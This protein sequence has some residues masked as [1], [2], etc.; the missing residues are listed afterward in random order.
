MSLMI[1]MSILNPQAFVVKNPRYISVLQEG[2][3][4]LVNKNEWISYSLMT[5]SGLCN[6]RGGFV[7]RIDSVNT[8]RSWG[9]WDSIMNAPN[10]VS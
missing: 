2:K 6:I 4:Y 7:R 3:G 1:T 5:N 8:Y 10:R 9:R